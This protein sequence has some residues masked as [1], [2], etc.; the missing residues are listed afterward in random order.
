MELKVNLNENSYS[1]ILG[2]NI[3]TSIFNYCPLDNKKVLIISD[4]GVPSF[5]YEKIL[6]QCKDGYKYIIKSGEES[7]NIDNY[8]LINKFLL[9]NEFTRNDLIIAVGGGVVGDL[10]AF[11]ASTFKRG[12]DFINIPTTSLSM[13]DSSVGG[14]TAIN[15]EGVKNVIGTFY[16]PKLVL[17]DFETLKT[18]DKRNFNNGLIEAL[19]MGLIKDEEIIS[20][21]NDF[22]KNIEKIIIKS[23][24]NK[25][26]IIE[27]DEKEKNLRKILN[28]GH[29]I[30]HAIE[31]NNKLLHG[32]AIARGMLY[33]LNDEIKLKLIKILDQLEIP[34]EYD[35]DY[36]QILSIIKNDKK[37]NGDYLDLVVVEKIGK[38]IIK[39]VT[40]K[41][42]E[43]ILKEGK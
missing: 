2:N 15:F 22:S 27:K 21:F 31:I 23:I 14:K 39:K 30:G 3:L 6:K 38:A 11:V 13:I 19:K 40:L 24:E 33:L 17:I 29:T 16:Q 37:M 36:S 1:I 7:K 12:L 20:L 35:L 42:I 10:A 4:D 28:F 43:K 5:Y 8:Y 25:I 26:E 41:E 34:R 18:L 9:N 32:E